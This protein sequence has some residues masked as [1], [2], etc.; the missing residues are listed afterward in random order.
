MVHKAV[1]SF[2]RQPRG[3]TRRHNF[4]PAMSWVLV[5]LFACED[6]GSDSSSSGDPPTAQCLIGCREG[7]DPCPAPGVA[8]TP[9]GYCPLIGQDSCATDADCANAPGG[10]TCA[11]V[12]GFL[13]CITPCGDHDECPAIETGGSCT[14]VTDDARRYCYGIEPCQSDADCAGTTGHVC[15]VPT[16]ACVCEQ[17][18]DCAILNTLFPVVCTTPVR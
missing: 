8:C 4:R 13:Q 5:L 14:G 16:G 10:P 7:A 12:R 6:S 18:A 11:P 9:E 2:A 3:G 15:H 1:E 17:A